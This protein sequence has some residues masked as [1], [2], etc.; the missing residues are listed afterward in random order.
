MDGKSFGMGRGKGCKGRA[1]AS[2]NEREIVASGG[3][4]NALYFKICSTKRKLALVAFFTMDNGKKYTSTEA[5][6]D[7]DT[8]TQTYRRKIK[9]P[10]RCSEQMMQQ[11]QQQ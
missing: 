7:N 5:N 4:G 8:H 9:S 11:Q 10:K 6:I 1:I 2:A 3:S